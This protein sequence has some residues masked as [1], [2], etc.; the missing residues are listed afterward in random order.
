MKVSRVRFVIELSDHG[1]PVHIA[2]LAPSDVLPKRQ[3]GRLRQLAELI[4]YPATK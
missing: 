1:L 3:V 2:T 4:A